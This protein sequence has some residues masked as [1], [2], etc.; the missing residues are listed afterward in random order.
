MT[1]FWHT[2]ILSYIGIGLIFLLIAISYTRFFGK[3]MLEESD[4]VLFTTAC[5]LGWPFFSIAM[6]IEFY[7]R[8]LR[9]VMIVSFKD[10]PHAWKAATINEINRTTGNGD[11]IESVA[12]IKEDEIKNLKVEINQLKQINAETSRELVTVKGSIPGSGQQRSMKR[13]ANIVRI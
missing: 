10:I 2:Y 13:L 12:S 6:S 5:T 7:N 4:A 8:V 3:S 1:L 9:H 11:G